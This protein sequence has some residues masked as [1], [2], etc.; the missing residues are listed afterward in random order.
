MCVE[1]AGKV[2]QAAL[3][4]DSSK[5]TDVLTGAGVCTRPENFPRRESRVSMEDAADGDDDDD[6]EM[7][8]ES[9]CA[10]RRLDVSACGRGG[11]FKLREDRRE[12]GALLLLRDNIKL[13]I[14]SP[15]HYACLAQS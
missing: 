12:A 15:P 6:D 4:V 14:V 13:D 7:T 3:R 2:H 11:K 9:A 8:T 5:L 1:V 10:D